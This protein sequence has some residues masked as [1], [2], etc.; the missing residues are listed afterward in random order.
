[1][2]AEDLGV[3]TPAV[4]ALRD[5]F[6]L[7]G[8]RVLQF[9]F[10]PDAGSDKHLPHRFVPHCVVYTGTHDNDTTRGWFTSSDV[11]TTQSREEIQAER[12]FARRYLRADGRTIHWDMI[13]LALSSVA[14]TAIIPLQDILG[15]DSRARMNVPGKPEGNWRWRFLKSQL[16]RRAQGRLAELTAV[17]SRWNGA[18]PQHL[19]RRSRVGQPRPSTG[20]RT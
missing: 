13:R 10:G 11:A 20:G 15:L 19:D 12:A 8:M 1:L 16:D 2:I 14:D 5:A 3:I 17:Y 4:E 6:G 7:P 18:I 9:G